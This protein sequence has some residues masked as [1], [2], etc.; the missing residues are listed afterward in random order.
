MEPDFWHERWKTNDIGFHEGEANWLLVKYFDRLALPQDARIFLPLCGK[1]R[2]IAWL[3]GKGYRV[4]GVEL[5]QTAVEQLFAELGVKPIV[6]RLTEMVL[7]RWENLEVFVGDFF[8]LTKL[9]LGDVDAVFD[10]AALVALP[11]SLRDRYTDHMIAITSGASQL[12]ISFDYD[13]SIMDGPPFSVTGQEIKA[14]YQNTHNVILLEEAP[15]EGGLK[16]KCEA[17]ES[18]RLLQAS[19]PQ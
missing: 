16:G 4:V 10:R 19:V 2:D 14:H 1:T 17:L 11:K 6:S 13:Q 18:A 7:Y 15:V 3:L 5:S 9:K 8:R 12:L